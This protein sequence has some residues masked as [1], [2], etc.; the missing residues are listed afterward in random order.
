M[1][2][3]I[4][5][6]FRRKKSRLISSVKY[7]LKFNAEMLLDLFYKWWCFDL[8][9]QNVHGFLKLRAAFSTESSLHFMVLLPTAVYIS[10]Y[11]LTKEENHRDIWSLTSVLHCSKL[12]LWLVYISQTNG[13][14]L[15]TEFWE[16]QPRSRAIRYH[17]FGISHDNSSA[18]WTGTI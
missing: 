9:A 1:R 2:V 6:T 18:N 4:K 16:S 7:K 17:S 14:I 11:W 12:A 13:N 10:C 3:K 15:C 5:Q 8:E